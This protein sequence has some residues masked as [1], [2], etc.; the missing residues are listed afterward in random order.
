MINVNSCEREFEEIKNNINLIAN[1]LEFKKKNENEEFKNIKKEKDKRIEKLNSFKYD[2]K[3]LIELYILIKENKEQELLKEILEKINL[4]KYETEKFKMEIFFDEKYDQM[5]AFLEIH[6]GSG[7]TDSQEW[8]SMLF[9]MYTE[10]FLK[11]KFT[12]K[13]N[14]ISN[15]EVSGIR[16]ISIKVSGENVFGWLKNESGI[17]RM[18]R[19]SP[20]DSNKRHTSFASV[21]IYPDIEKKYDFILK[22]SDLKIDTFRSCGAGGQHVN[23]T[24]SAV[25]ITHIPSGIVVKCQAERSQHKNKAQAIK[26]LKSK[27]YVLNEEK[28]KINKEEKKI[29]ATWGNQIR[30]YI[31]DKSIIKDNRTNIEI[32]DVNLILNN[33]DLDRFTLAIINSKFKIYEK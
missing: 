16:F 2:T 7:G 29:S 20:F 12:Y 25:R 27:L 30:S 22:E 33:G 15:G 4:L 9:K 18:V 11:H 26:Q 13:I 19:K 17:H 24:D 23:T 21:F 28:N 8:V 6:S 14:N 32:N 31:L 1:C 10:W 5:E 3:S